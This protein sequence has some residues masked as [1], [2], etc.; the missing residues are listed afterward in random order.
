MKVAKR[1]LL[2]FE[3]SHSTRSPGWAATPGS[4]IRKYVDFR[5]DASHLRT[6][7]AAEVPIRVGLDTFS[8][9]LDALRQEQFL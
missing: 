2:P 9:A 7:Y 6:G 5:I 8:D 4:P 3:R 1:W